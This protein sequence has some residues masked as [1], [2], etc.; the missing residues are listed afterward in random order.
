MLS[1]YGMSNL[2]IARQHASLVLLKGESA[3]LMQLRGAENLRN[4]SSIQ[5]I[6]Y[7]LVLQVDGAVFLFIALVVCA[8]P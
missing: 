7:K 2:L 1:N 5:Y 4:T 3:A 6:A 8:L